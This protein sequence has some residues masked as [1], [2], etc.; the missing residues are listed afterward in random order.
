MLGNL[1]TLP[2]YV[3]Y[4]EADFKPIGANIVCVMIEDERKTASGLILPSKDREKALM[5]KVIAVGQGR[6]TKNGKV[7]AMPVK[8]GDV[9]IF[10]RYSGAEVRSTDKP[11]VLILEIDDVLAVV[12]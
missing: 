2:P 1:T 12:K 6:F 4:R 8:K 11:A 7:M 10:A 3:L 9:I 5:A